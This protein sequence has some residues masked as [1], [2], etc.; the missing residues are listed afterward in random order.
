MF[1]VE[2]TGSEHLFEVN[3]YNSQ[4]VTFSPIHSAP[5]MM[6]SDIAIVGCAC[7]VLI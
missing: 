3:S 4:S 7:I 1:G 6:L 2:I 5:M